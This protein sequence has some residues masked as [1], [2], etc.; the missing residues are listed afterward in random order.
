MVRGMIVL[1]CMGVFTSTAQ[2]D[3]YIRPGLLGAG[4]TI[5]P[6]F[7]LNKSEMN[8]YIT[9]FLEGFVDKHV[10]I[11]GE[12]HYFVDGKED[13]PFLKNS[14]RTHFGISYHRNHKNLDGFIN[15]MPGAA[16]MQINGA[17]KPNGDIQTHVVPSFKVGVGVTYY[18]W[19]IFNFFAEVSYY[20][21][22]ARNLNNVDGRTDELMISAGLAFNVN[23]IRAK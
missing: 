18:V 4:T 11:R 6:S 23:T 9:G 17:Y 13:L 5:S 16:I 14:I 20:N 19:K 12:T 1:M 2:Q 3:I 15:F 7:M 10:S 21:S 8:Y 22:T